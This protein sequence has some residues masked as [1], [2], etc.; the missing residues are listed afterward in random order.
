[1][2]EK[3][4]IR[5]LQKKLAAGNKACNQLRFREAESIYRECLKIAPYHVQVLWNLGVLVQRRA[6]N[7]A[8]RREAMDL[9]H[10]VIKYSN[11]DVKIASSAFTNMGVMMGKVN[12]IEEAEICFGMALQMNPE[13]NAARINFADVLRHN[14]KYS[15]ANREFGEVL[16]LDPESAAAKFSTGMI[17]LL[18]GDLLGGFELYES[19][20]D[21]ESFPT[22]RFQSEKPLW[23]FIDGAL[24]DLDGKTLLVWEEQGFGDTFMFCRYFREIKKRWPDAKI[25]FR[26]NPL[27]RNIAKGIDGLDLFMSVESIPLSLYDY[28]CPIMSLPNR[29][30]TTLE[31]VPNETLYIA[32]HESWQSYVMSEKVPI[33]H[34]DCT[35]IGLC[36]AG[37]PRHGKDA[38]RSLDPEAFQPMIDAH[39]EIQFYSLQVGPRADECARLKN[40]IDLAPTITDFTDTAQA[41][42]QLDLIVSVDTAVVH[43]CGALG[44]PCH[45]L[46]PMSP[47]WRWLL[48]G[49]T[50]P[51]YPRLRLFRQEKAGDWEPVLKRISE[52][53]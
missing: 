23:D 34:L 35:R 26:G 53:L 38:W 46:C 20:F 39:P 37:S 36:W 18:M 13:N 51:W 28:H 22:K 48:T 12:H 16:R 9:Y 43:L 4:Q 29:F 40:V 31:T 44:K 14:G 25:W 45:M 8:E 52:A 11:G 24:P 21:V 15:E 47:D 42:L 49:E 32:P 5:L 27:Y 33:E 17:R 1:M 10:D 3:T 2:S 19:R 41:I 30:G 6:D 7:P 50:S